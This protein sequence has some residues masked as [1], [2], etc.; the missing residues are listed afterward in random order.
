MGMFRI[1]GADGKTYRVEA[2]DAESASRAIDDM[3]TAQP[4][5]GSTLA[6]ASPNQWPT[7]GSPLEISVT[8]PK[9]ERGSILDAF[10]QG[11]TFGTGDEI[12]GAFGGA[13][14]WMG[15]GPKGSEGTF[16]E[17]Y[18]RTVAKARG[19]LDAYRERNPKTALAAE[20]GG[21][22]ATLPI[23]GPVNLLRAPAAISRGATLAAKAGNMASRGSVATAN[24]AATGA[25][26]GGLYGAG[27]AE[28]GVGARAKGALEAAA[29]AAAVGAAAPAITKGIKEAAPRVGAILGHPIRTGR[30]LVVPS[31]EAERRVV[32][33]AEIDAGEGYLPAALEA[34]EDFAADGVPM[35]P[36]DVGE[37]TRA[38][39]RSAANT[40]PAGRD[41]LNQMVDNRFT[42]QIDRATDVVERNAPGIN[43]TATRDLLKLAE[44]KANAPLYKQAMRDGENGIWHEGLEQLTYAPAMQAAIRDAAKTGA[45]KAAVEG[46]RPPKPPFTFQADGTMSPVPN[47]KPNLRFWDAVKQNLYDQE[48]AAFRSGNK[49]AGNDIKDIRRQLV[50]YLDDAVPSYANARG[51][52][53]AFFGADDALTAGEAFVTSRANNAEA[54]KIVDAMKP[55]ER[56]LFAHGFASKFVADLREIGLRRSVITSKV[57]NSPAAKERLEIALGPKATRELEAFLYIENI[58]DLGRKAVQGNSTTARQLAELGLAGGAGLVAGGGDLTDPKTVSVALLTGILLRGGRGFHKGIDERVSREVAE[59]L[60]TQDPQRFKQAIERASRNPKFVEVLGKAHDGLTRALLPAMPNGGPQPAAADGQGN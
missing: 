24:S 36:L 2:P 51:T 3:R 55:A 17:G 15:F 37:T 5:G 31:S 50:T 39:G 16:G 32:R 27:S 18:D 19:D 58:M 54:R 13:M 56:T 38:L 60:S 46:V 25:A 9:D 4:A 59:I 42:S 29:F 49:G 20:I 8:P 41:A 52:A 7:D 33:A 23:S 45:N 53:A 1:Q 35:A 28:G 30:G 6:G 34:L 57:F 12:A 21:A 43:S 22:L 48:Q 47:V 14:D 40:S 44:K 11:P 10:I 26:Y